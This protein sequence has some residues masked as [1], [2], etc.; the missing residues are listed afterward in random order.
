MHQLTEG[1]GGMSEPTALVQTQ[2]FQMDTGQWIGQYAG[3][4]LVSH[5]QPIA[6]F[7]DDHIR[8]EGYEALIRPSRDGRPIAPPVFFETLQ[9]NESFHV[10]WLCRALHLRNFAN[11]NRPDKKLYLNLDPAAYDS[12]D[13]SCSQI[14]IMKKRAES[15]GLQSDLLVCEIVEHNSMADDALY[16]AIDQFR[17][18]GS[19]IAID[20]F[21][22]DSSNFDRLLKMKPDI[23]KIDGTLLAKSRQSP[24]LRKL[25]QN[26]AALLN[27]LDIEFASEGIEDLE[28]L[29]FVLELGATFGQG[30]YLARPTD[31]P[32]NDATY[33]KTWKTALTSAP[34]TVAAKP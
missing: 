14:S 25:Y 27:D 11:L 16:A 20:D 28:D 24:Q 23:V 32:A 26:I 6:R 33:E 15:M 18:I 5:F 17:S 7:C 34:D 21:G 31:Q 22:T 9:S 4:Q 30:F 19:R 8:V 3:Y 2:L 12:T 1:D 29:K 10:D 13:K